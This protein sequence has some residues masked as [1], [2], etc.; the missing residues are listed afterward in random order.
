MTRWI[1]ARAGRVAPVMLLVLGFLTIQVGSWGADEPR[2]RQLRPGPVG[3]TLNDPGTPAP[4]IAPSCPAFPPLNLPGVLCE[5]FDAERNGVGGFQWSRLPLGAFPGDPLRAIGDPN[6]DILGY[7]MSGGPTPL[8]TGG[9]TCSD[10]MGGHVGCQAPVAEENDW[11]LHSPFEGPGAGYTPPGRPPGGAPD[12]GKAHSGFRSMHM[13][14]HLDPTTTLQDTLRLR[15]VSA[16]VLDSQGDPNIPGVV[17]GPGSSLEFWQIISVPDDENFGYGFI[18]PGT[19]FGGGQV[20]ISLLGVDGRF[21]RWQVLTPVFNGYDS[22]IHETSPL[23]GFDPTDDVIP[24]A[25]ETM[26]DHSPLY[27]DKGD[28]FGIDTTCTTDTDGNDAAHKDCG[29]LSCTPGDGCTERGSRGLGV[30]TR[31]VFNLSTFAGRVAR[32]RWIGMVEGGWSWATDRSALEPAS[33]PAYQY[34]DGDDG[35]WIDD[36]VL[37]DL[38][39]SPAPCGQTDD[40]GDGFTQ[41]QRDCDDAKPSVY[42]GAPEICDGIN[43][44][45]DDPAWPAIAAEVDADHDGSSVCEGDCDDARATVYPGAAEICDGFNNDCDDP[46]WPAP[47]P[48]DTDADQDSWVICAGDCDDTRASVHPG[49]SQICD[50]L[51]NDCNDP[52]WPA[53]PANEQDTDGDAAPNCND[54]DPANPTVYP[55]APELCDGIRNNCSVFWNPQLEKDDDGDGFAECQGDCTDQDFTAWT[56]WNGEVMLEIAFDRSTGVTT[57]GWPLLTAGGATQALYD[58]LWNDLGSLYFL[59]ADCLESNGTDG[60]A[61]EPPHTPSFIRYYLVRAQNGCPTSAEGGLETWS[62]GTPRAGRKCP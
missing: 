48:S 20:Q 26:C 59:S 16:F 34:Y 12:G 7:T 61:V 54:C 18:P 31:S 27:A 55:G 44:D 10:D 15:Q 58:V 41:C 36:I 45:C 33:Q 52:A 60:V 3:S 11:H 30:W 21:E 4:P 25:T 38:R 56:P 23:C 42:P 22:T 6:D 53:I 29:D 47:H 39:Q 57:L 2:E 37:T 46:G 35:W 49:A 50:G 8:G 5:T 24:P 62:D 9:V 32:L 28:V 19:S 1:R 51:N 17:P 13:G 43:N 40:D 14:R